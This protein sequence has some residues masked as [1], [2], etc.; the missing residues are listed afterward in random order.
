M[1]AASEW[2]RRLDRHQRFWQPLVT[3]EGAYI[4]VTAPASG[5]AE[6]P[7]TGS[8]LEQ[9]GSSRQLSQQALHRQWFNIEQRVAAIEQQ[10]EQTFYGGDA[11]PIAAIDLGSGTLPALLGRPYV[12]APE[13]IWFDTEPLADVEQ[14]EALSLQVGSRF[15]QAY[16]QAYELLFAHSEGRFLVSATDLGSSL[17]TLAALYD[18]ANLL[19]DIALEPQKL[20]RLLSKAG[21]WRQQ[22]LDRYS[23]LVRA[24]QT[25]YV[26]YAPIASRNNY[27]H[28]EAELAAMISPQAFAELIVPALNSETPSGQLAT[29]LVDGDSYTRYLPQILQINNLHAVIWGP[30]TRIGSDGRAAKNWNEPA[31]VEF[32]KAVQA[33]GIKLIILEIPAFQVGQLM[34]QINPDGV[35]MQVAADS[36]PQAEQLLSTWYK[37]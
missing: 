19:V 34:E 28:H 2:Q 25:S 5:Q 17:D 9:L 18:R 15:Y 8:D 32:I 24:A 10:I 16:V 20:R 23:D 37:G 29:Y 36:R 4:A 3:G 14:I 22:V 30:N 26:Y 12:L 13:T 31:S 11:L 33:A 1:I 35:F 21:R 27:I 7:A 6:Y